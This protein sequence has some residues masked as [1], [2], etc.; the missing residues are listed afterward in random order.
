MKEKQKTASLIKMYSFQDGGQSEKVIY[1]GTLRGC[2]KRIPPSK[3]DQF[4]IDFTK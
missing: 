2:K 1:T 4:R 3:K